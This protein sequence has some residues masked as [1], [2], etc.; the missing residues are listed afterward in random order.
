MLANNVVLCFYSEK[1]TDLLQESSCSQS[2][3]RW[4]FKSIVTRSF[5]FNMFLK[6]EARGCSGQNEAFHLSAVW[7]DC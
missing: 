2:D 3:C 6:S 5:F 7:T 4:L 1:P